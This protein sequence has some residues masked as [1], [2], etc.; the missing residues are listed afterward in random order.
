MSS[1]TKQ[2]GYPV[3]DAD[4]EVRDGQCWLKLRQS[5]FISDGGADE[6]KS[7]W[8]VPIGI[9]TNSS[10]TEPRA[11]ILLTKAEEEFQLNDVNP[12]EWIKVGS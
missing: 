11:K 3:V 10:A 7:I 9:L 2:M 5:R 12:N 8:Q 6:A 1:W 4:I